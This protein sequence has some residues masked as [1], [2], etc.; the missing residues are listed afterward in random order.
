ML[1]VIWIPESRQVL[2]DEERVATRSYRPDLVV[3]GNPKQFPDP[4][5]FSVRDLKDAEVPTGVTGEEAHKRIQALYV[6]RIKQAR[7]KT[8]GLRARLAARA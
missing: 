4:V 8:H 7:A 6:E 1:T 2:N 5:K 3:P